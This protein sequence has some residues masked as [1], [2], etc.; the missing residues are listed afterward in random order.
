MTNKMLLPLLLLVVIS[1][2]VACGDD[3]TS[4]APA[5]GDDDPIGDT[6]WVLTAGEVDGAPLT[7]LE[8]HAVT[9]VRTDDGIGG[10]AACNNYGGAVT[11]DGSTV[12]VGDLFRTEMACEPPAAMDLESAYL[13]ALVRVD[14]VAVDGAGLTLSGDGVT[15]TYAARAPEPDAA[16]LGT[17]WM[18]DT[19]IEGEAASTPVAGADASMIIDADG[20]ISGTTG[21]NRF[22]GDVGIGD[23]SFGP[24]ELASTRMACPPD[25]M[26]Q[27]AT[28]LRVL[29]GGPSWSIE[30]PLLTLTLGD[31]TGLVYRAG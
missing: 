17:T 22:M 27:E 29:S 10:T 2:A 19:I 9:L 3:E 8:T 15:L 13:A 23:D 31:G 24:A 14:T 12:T 1:L 6:D 30:G 7:L 26:A 21:C 25:V 28:V 4:T 18:L 5:G 16:L 11:F 20:A